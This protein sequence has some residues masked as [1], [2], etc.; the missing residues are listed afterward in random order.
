MSGGCRGDV[1]GM[2]G[3]CRGRYAK[4]RLAMRSLTG[5]KNPDGP[6]DPIIVHADVRKNLLVQKAI[7]EGGRSMIYE[8]AWLCYAMLCY[9][10]PCYAM[11]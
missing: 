6:A 7:V 2:S 5:D 9:A 10:M 1:V 8:C 3:G 4:E 11:L